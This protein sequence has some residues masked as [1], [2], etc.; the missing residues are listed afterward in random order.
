MDKS[1]FVLVVAATLQLQVLRKCPARLSRVISSNNTQQQQQHS[2][3]SVIF[4]N[5]IPKWKQH[6]MHSS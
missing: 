6:A 5:T 2:S 4:T 1:C 3:S